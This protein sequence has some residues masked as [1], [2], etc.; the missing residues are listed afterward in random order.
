MLARRLLIAAGGGGGTV[1]PA[2]TDRYALFNG[3]ATGADYA[4]GAAS[5]TDYGITWTEYASNPVLSAGAGG[6]WDDGHVKDPCLL[7]DGSQY[8][9]YYA[10]YDGASYQIGRATATSHNG[11]WTKDASNPVL[12]LG[13]GGA[14]DDA[15]CAFPA[16]LYEP[17]DTGKEWKMWYRADDGAVQTIGYAH[18]SD[19]I[20]WTKVGKVLDVGAGGT[21]DDVG[22]LPGGII[23]SG[24]TYYLLYGGRQSAVAPV[25]W[26][27]GAATF[28]NPEGTY[29]K[30]AGNPTLLAGFNTSG[31][32]QSLTADTTAGSNVVTVGDTSHWAAGW[33][34]LLVDGNSESE[35]VVIASVDS[36]TQVTLTTT[37]V[38]TF[39]TANGAVLRPVEMISV[40][41]RT[42]LAAQGGGW[43]MFYTPFQAQDDLSPG[44]TLLREMSARAT[45]SALD[46]AW[47][48]DHATGILFDLYPATTG[49]HK[50]S[51]ENPSVIVA[52]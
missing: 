7:W 22:V 45:A 36:G 48:L 33:T 42:V 15:G 32:S 51:A 29:T 4:I 44:G 35:V 47:T 20:S 16:V 34:M 27:V 9:M 17:T 21:W 37:A 50:F 25:K 2:A 3:G 40:T 23:K 28:T 8:V 5:S 30:A 10:G 31:I 18:S 11:S 1:L 46:G 19:G 26:Q 12:A 13:A 24:S 49:W 39:A 38:G 43:E 6:A 52:P 41:P 14:F